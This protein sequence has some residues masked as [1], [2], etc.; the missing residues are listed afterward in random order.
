MLPPTMT[1]AQSTRSET[2]KRKQLGSNPALG[3]VLCRTQIYY[4]A[5]Q[6]ASSRDR[7][8]SSRFASY[9]STTLANFFV[10]RLMF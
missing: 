10:V 1:V 5:R 4:S 3:I 7:T 9:H 2:A 8:R 6:K